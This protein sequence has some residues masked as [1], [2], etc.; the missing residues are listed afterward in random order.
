MK[1][2]SDYNV[3]SFGW[4][5][6]WSDAV[7][8]YMGFRSANVTKYLLLPIIKFVKLRNDS[9]PTD[10]N[11][12]LSFERTNSCPD[13]LFVHT[14]CLS[15]ESVTECKS[16]SKCGMKKLASALKEPYIVNGDVA[17]EGAWPWYAQLYYNGTSW[18][19][20]S[21]ISDQW[22]LTAAHC[23]LS[24]GLSLSMHYVPNVEFAFSSVMHITR[25]VEYG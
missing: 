25:D 13:K 12:L 5:D 3:C 22:L 1:G 4:S 18:C 7:C 14:S 24:V 6:S 16:Q 23:L 20:A 8:K 10:A 15:Y 2:V 17:A 19:G 9:K 21:I 11:A